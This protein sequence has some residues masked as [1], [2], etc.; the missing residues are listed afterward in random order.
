[1]DIAVVILN[2]NGLKMLQTYLPDLVAHT[3]CCGAFVVVA[4][5]GSTDGSVEWLEAEW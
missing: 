4:D 2:W 3:T 5:N 1:M